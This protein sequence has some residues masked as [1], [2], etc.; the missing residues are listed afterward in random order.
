MFPEK[1]PSSPEQQKGHSPQSVPKEYLYFFD[2]YILFQFT[3]RS[4]LMEKMLV[5]FGEFRDS[6]VEVLHSQSWTDLAWTIS[7]R[8][9]HYRNSKTLFPWDWVLIFVVHKN[10]RSNI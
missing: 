6:P 5:G 4:A 1:M 2:P 8:F 9:A 7:G 3:L 10:V